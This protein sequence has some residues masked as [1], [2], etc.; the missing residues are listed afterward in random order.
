[1]S[2]P[3]QAT[4]IETYRQRSASYHIELE[5]LRQ[6]SD[7]FANLRLVL[8]G[9]ALFAVIF[10]FANA[11]WWFA[12]AVGLLIGFVWVLIQHN[13]VEEQRQR[14][15]ALY[16][17][18]HYGVQRL[19][20]DW[21]NLPLRVP[22]L[23][24]PADSYANDLDLV[25]RA[26]LLHLLGH[27]PTALGLDTLLSWL[28]APA[29]PNTITARQQ[30]IAELAQNVQLREELH[31][32]AHHVSAERADFEQFLVW[33]EQPARVLN[34]MW[35]VWL[36]R[37]LP[38]GP[39]AGLVA[40]LAGW[41]NVPYW[42]VLFILNIIVS[43]GL[44]LWANQ[45]IMA[46]SARR[47]GF[48]GFGA[49]FRAINEPQ[50][51]ATLL[52]QAQSQLTANGVRADHQMARLSRLLSLADQRFSYFYIVLQ[53]FSLWNIHIGWLLE[54][55]QRDVRGQARAW[56]T[57]LGEIEALAALATLQADHPN[58]TQAQLHTNDQVIA[59]GL[60]HPLLRPDKA[61]ANDLSI[62]PAGTLFLIT[63]SNMAGKST[64]MRAIGLNIVLAQ[65]GSVVCANN[66]QLPV[67]RLA[68]SMRI[69]DSL[70]QGVS[71]YMAELLRLKMVLGEVEQARAAG[72]PALFLLD[73]I[74]HGTNTR[75][76][77]VAA[78][79]IIARLIGL[80]AIGAVSTHDLSLATAPDIAAISQPWY[81]TEHFER[82]DNGPSMTF[83]YQLRAGL[84]P[85]TNALKLM[86]IVGLVD[87]D[88]PLSVAANS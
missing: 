17:L 25:G 52:R 55:W 73:E 23:D 60:A 7:R 35:V 6:H 32:A 63:G 11:P 50:F 22:G 28:L 42:L 31:V 84:A 14:T 71:Y 16:Q 19:E 80:G 36:A 3:N 20:R 78:R 1:M 18:N 5:Q 59:S 87:Q 75:E 26:S 81:L 13:T 41:T 69:N 47:K 43:N 82:G 66:L 37:L 77:T 44:G 45:V 40:Y 72:Q 65:T 33:T 58:W 88:V 10:G 4:P 2:L 12:V 53:G 27:L 74:L 85:S 30:A 48:A 21:V 54:R 49:L 15:Q 76:R 67:L 79:H 8:F 34:R 56:L 62:G 61:V 83:D 24:I 64:L 68:T 46:V 9:A 29:T 70:E 38:I 39:I 57:T 51:Q 86:E